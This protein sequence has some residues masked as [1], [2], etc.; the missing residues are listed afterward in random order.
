MKNFKIENCLITPSFTFAQFFQLQGYGQYGM[1]INILNI[2]TN[3]NLVQN[4]LFQML[5]NDYLI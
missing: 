5:Y 1:H 3:L 4:V 2:L